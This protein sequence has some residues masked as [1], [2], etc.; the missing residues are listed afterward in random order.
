MQYIEAVPRGPLSR[1]PQQS[2]VVDIMVLG[3]NIL[4]AL[5]SRLVRIVH[6]AIYRA[7]G[8]SLTT[9]LSTVRAHV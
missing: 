2:T 8:H 5:G 9:I 3:S 4:G 6:A 7:T 1:P